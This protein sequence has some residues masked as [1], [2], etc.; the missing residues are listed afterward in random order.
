MPFLALRYGLSV[1]PPT[2]LR[3]KCAAVT[4]ELAALLDACLRMDPKARPAL[5]ELARALRSEHA[6][7][8]A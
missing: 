5:A 2:P 6:R 3:D 1:P 7:R 8:S 4:P